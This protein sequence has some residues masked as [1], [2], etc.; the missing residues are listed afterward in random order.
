MIPNLSNH[1][2]TRYIQGMFE[3]SLL[4]LGLGCASLPPETDLVPS[5]PELPI[6][7]EDAQLVQN[8]QTVLLKWH[9]EEIPIAE[10][11]W[12]AAFRL[13]DG[14]GVILSAQAGGGSV[15]VWSQ[16]TGA[17]WES[18]TLVKSRQMIDRLCVNAAETQ[19]AFVW[20]GPQGGVA[21][22]YRM[23][24]A[25]HARP[26]RVSNL[27][28]QA[29]GPPLDFIPLPLGQSLHFEGQQ[30]AWES[31]EGPQSLVLP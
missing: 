18:Y 22:I 2:L 1:P 12:D 29:S 21:G 31:A 26:V 7:A 10:G 28:L 24:L 14:H 8:A 13:K 9:G 6:L 19:I 15:L 30:L 25:R 23:D 5:P 3:L 20:S 11:V 16:Q 4:W 27:Q 17:G